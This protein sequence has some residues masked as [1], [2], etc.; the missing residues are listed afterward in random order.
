MDVPTHKLVDQCP[1]VNKLSWR[2]CRSTFY[3]WHVQNISKRGP[4][5]RIRGDVLY[6]FGTILLW[7][8]TNNGNPR[9]KKGDRNREKVGMSSLTKVHA[10]YHEME[11]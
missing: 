7:G 3:G 10:S 1:M 11:N 5:Y 2:F 8:I 9:G 4:G 6:K